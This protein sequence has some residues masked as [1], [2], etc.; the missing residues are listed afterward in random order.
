MTAAQLAE[1]LE[2]SVRTIYRDV[3]SLLAAGVPLLGEAGHDGGYALVGGYRTRLNGLTGP[4]AEALFLAGLPGAAADLGLGSVL[5]AAELKLLSALT[6]EMRARAGRIRERFHLDAPGW[7]RDA[8]E[9]PY[10]PAMALAVWQCQAVEVRYHRWYA[11]EIVSRRLEPYGLVLKAGRWYAVA[12]SGG[13][14]LRTYRVDQ[15]LALRP[16]GE[17][18][19]PPPDFD[20]AAYWQR[21]TAALQDRLWQQDAQIRI[22]PAGLTRLREL[23]VPV[24]ITAAEA[25]EEEQPGGWR[26]ATVPIES[27]THAEGEL[28]RLGAEVEVLAPTELRQRLAKAAQG[29]ARLYGQAPSIRAPRVRQDAVNN[30]MASNS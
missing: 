19:A 22:S 26:R 14:A 17:E 15:V 18:F 7:Y 28:L 2:V 9:V 27:L 20:L 16:T 23:A 30:V 5:A 11:P 12:R 13:G 24:V 4:E 8:E 6:P 10:L 29:L 3:E 1:E 21:H 25:G